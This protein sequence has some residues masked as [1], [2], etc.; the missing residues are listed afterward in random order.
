MICCNT[1]NFNHFKSAQA[2][3]SGHT[4]YILEVTGL[5][6]GGDTVHPDDFRF[7]KM[8]LVNDVDT[9]TLLGHSFQ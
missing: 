6:A 3:Y 4:S 5:N 1:K 8:P 7:F 9:V 2:G